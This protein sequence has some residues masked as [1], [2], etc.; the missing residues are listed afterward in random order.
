M[1][2]QGC[3]CYRDFFLMYGYYCDDRD[4]NM[5]CGDCPLAE[6]ARRRNGN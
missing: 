1:G 2:Y 5:S 4:K 6:E 3:P